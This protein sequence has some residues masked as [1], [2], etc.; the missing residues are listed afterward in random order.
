[1]NSCGKLGEGKQPQQRGK[2]ELRYEGSGA[3]DGPTIYAAA[4]YEPGQQR[5]AE[6]PRTSGSNLPY[7]FLTTA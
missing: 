4:R 7:S 5:S 6:M 2:R 1:M 3:M